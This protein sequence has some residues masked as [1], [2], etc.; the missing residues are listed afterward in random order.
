MVEP[1]QADNSELVSK[2]KRVMGYDLSAGFPAFETVADSLNMSPPTLRRHLRKEGV[3]YQSL[4]DQLRRDAAIAYLSRPELSVSAVSALMGFTIESWDVGV[5][6]L[7]GG[8]VNFH[9]SKHQRHIDMIDSF[10]EY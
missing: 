1:Q 8:R 3:S 4:K 5:A 10:L 2:V 7:K 9:Y 6:F